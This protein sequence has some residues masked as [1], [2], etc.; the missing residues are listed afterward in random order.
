MASS[1]WKEC[2]G[3][4]PRPYRFAQERTWAVARTPE[5]AAAYVMARASRI[6]GPLDRA[7]LQAAVDGAFARHEMLRTTFAE[8]DGRPVQI[9]HPPG[10]V[11]LPVIDV[12]AGPNPEAEAAGV[13]LRESRTPFDLERGPLLRL[14]LVRLSDSEH[15]LVRVHHHLVSDAWSWKMFFDELGL[16]YEARREGRPSPLPEEM[17]VQYG[18]FAVWERHRLRPDAPRYRAQVDAW[19]RELADSPPPLRLPFERSVPDGGVAPADGVI[20]WGLESSLSAA[21]EGRAREWRATYYMVRLALFGALLALETGQHDLILG[22]YVT[23]RRRP[24]LQQLFGYFANLT[25]LRL[26][27]S[28]ELSV[29]EWIRRV[30]TGV[31][32]TGA[33]AEIPYEQ[34]AEELRACGAAVPEL[35]AI[36]GT[37]DT[38]PRLS[39]GGLEI[40]PIPP[41]FPVM[42]WGFT[43]NM[44]R[45]RETDSCEAAFDA[46]IYDPAGVRDFLEGYRCLA[47]AF[48][49]RPDAPLGELGARTGISP[50]PPCNESR[51]P[52]S[53]R[54]PLHY[55]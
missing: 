36:F 55:E 21:L 7:A 51:R 24:E 28:P 3:T 11:E 43:V 34:L 37:L 1:P 2:P 46:R 25:T 49:D 29:S 38:D 23:N 16:R 12:S 9:I 52:D 4:S 6:R 41:V 53:N 26:R 54:G 20:F 5:G 33:R 32:E 48:V 19:R 44:D 10:P 39:F 50:R 15:H 30:R 18:D 35:R 47:R 13:F 42:P 45:G 27:F 31:I 8:R 14:R 17:P 22:S 40:T